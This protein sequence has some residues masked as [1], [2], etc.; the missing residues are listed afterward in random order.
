MA[1][2]LVLRKSPDRIA[3]TNQDE[4][5]K[6][7]EIKEVAEI[8]NTEAKTAEVKKMDDDMKAAQLKHKADKEALKLADVKAMTDK[9]IG[10]A[11]TKLMELQEKISAKEETIRLL[12]EREA[13]LRKSVRDLD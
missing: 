8:K 5:N 4:A 7:K 11:D 3:K 2:L 1:Q 12:E 6:V 13:Q 10:V 9:E